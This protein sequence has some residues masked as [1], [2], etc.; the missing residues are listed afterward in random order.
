M[1]TNV[2][3]Y[4]IVVVDVQNDFCPGGALPV[5][6]GDK[7]VTPLN[8]M[9]QQFD[10]AGFPVF[11]TRD[12]HPP[13]HCS[14]KQQ[15]G[16]WPPHCVKNTTGAEFHPRLKVP[17]NARIIS[18]AT[19]SD[20]D[21]YSGFQGTDLS[22][23]LKRL[24]VTQL[25]LGGLATDYCVKNTVLDA[26]RDGFGVSVLKDCV[27][28]VEVKRGDSAAALRDMLA[29]G[30]TI[31]ESREVPKMLHRRVTVMSSS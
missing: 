24:G 8:E 3:K 9:I 11:F 1:G 23:R 18:K 15:G 14:F 7:V 29:N 5:K 17:R 12:W 20:E 27:K 2:T 6:A 31:I 10:A 19:K 21:A 25:I 26:L 30:A 16:I 22:G 4:A 28:G 13:N